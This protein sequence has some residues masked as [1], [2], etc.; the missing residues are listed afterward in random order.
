ME[1]IVEEEFQAFGMKSALDRHKGL[2]D[3]DAFNEW[4]YNGGAELVV[5]SRRV[6]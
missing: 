3:L 1:R 2:R 6:A 5:P 4:A